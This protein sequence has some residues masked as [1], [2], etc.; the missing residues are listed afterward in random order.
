MIRFLLR[1]LGLLFLAAAFIFL[2]YDGTRS[3]AANMLLYSKVDE[4]WSLVHQ[5]S[6]QQLQPL[7]E[8]KAP[9]WAWDPVMMTVLDAPA[10]LVLALVGAILILL[11]RR[12]KPLI[13]YAR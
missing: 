10:T 12:K 5:A 1:T 9:P 2:V 4:I 3:I 6:L 7:I 8:K 11:G 13:G